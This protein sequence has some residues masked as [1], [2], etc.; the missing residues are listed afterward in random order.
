MST[1]KLLFL[2]DI[3]A[4]SGRKAVDHF[5]PQL[6][7]EYDLDLVLAN[8]ENAANG[9]GISQR[10]VNELNTS[11]VDYMTSG[12]HI[13]YVHDISSYLNDPKSIVLRPYNFSSSAPGRGVGVVETKNGV[14]VGVINLMGRVFMEPGVNLPFDAIDQAILEIQSECD[15][16]VL[17]MHAETTSEKRAMGWHLDGKVSLVVGS[18]THVQTAD[19]EILPQG[20]G[21]IS[22][23]GMCGPYDSVI[24][25]DRHKVLKKMRTGLHE[26]FQ[27]G[28]NDI[29]LC[30]VFCEIDTNTKKALRIERVCRKMEES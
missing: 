23:M 11:G 29:R 26:K 7:K 4:E 27:P 10:L 12:N 17:D 19:E 5:V 30:G 9:R 28:R 16:M 20:T 3:F 2:G 18:H 15:F 21:F 1:V 22:D 13:F 24:G 8:C 6:K 14:K 25:M